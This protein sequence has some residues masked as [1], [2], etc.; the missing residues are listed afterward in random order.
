[1]SI[2]RWDKKRDANEG[3]I[4]EALERAGALV[5]QWDLIDLIVDFRQHWRL[6]EVK[7]SAK[8]K[9]T[10]RQRNFI[11]AHPGMVE[12]VWTPMMALRAIGAISG[13]YEHE[14]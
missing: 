13:G 12:V 2:N 7:V 5:T 6:L 3:E 9:L 8:S 10:E 11:A 4:I 1:M 14:Q